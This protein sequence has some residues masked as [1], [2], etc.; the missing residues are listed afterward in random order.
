MW[1]AGD[2]VGVGVSGGSD[3]VALLLILKEI[4]RQQGIR[5][6]VAHFNHCL[7]GPESDRDEQFVAEL[8][9]RLDLP[10][11]S[12]REDVAAVARVQRWNLEDAARRLRY[13]FF[14]SLITDGRMG[15]VAVAHTADDQAETVLARI[16]RGTGPTG[17]S[18]IYPVNGKIVRPLL[19]VRRQELRGYLKDLGQEWR[20]D[21]TNYDRSRLRSR[22]RHEVLPDLQREISPAV[23]NHLGRLAKMAREDEAFWEAFIGARLKTLVERAEAQM[24]IRCSDLLNPLPGADSMV[25]ADA[26]DGRLAVTRRLVRAMVDEVR[27]NRRQWTADHVERVVHLARFGRSGSRLELPGMNVE[28]NFDWLQFSAAKHPVRGRSLGKSGVIS[29]FSRIVELGSL[30]DSTVVALPEIRRRFHLKVVDWHS[31]GSDTDTENAVDRDL[32][33]PP[34]VLRNWQPGDSLRPKG[35]RS[36]RKL[37]QFLRIKRVALR[38]RAGWPVLTSGDMLVWVRGLPVA[39]EFATRSTTRVGVV[40]AEESL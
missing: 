8:A 17:L 15:R 2:R 29:E 1:R 28:K 11:F 31:S 7:R 18:A 14:D 33:H 6:A 12:G 21:A 4:C 32:L 36:S 22:L 30:G 3:S 37:K 5:L 38:E 23:V 40:I 20:E 35:R 10:F 34:L 24:R 39:A 16:V 27:G 25:N 26:E 19:E 9:R 13:G